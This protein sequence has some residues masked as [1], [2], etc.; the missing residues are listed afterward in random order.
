MGFIERRFQL[1]CRTLAPSSSFKRRFPSCCSSGEK[2]C[3]RLARMFSCEQLPAALWK[4]SVNN[5][6][7]QCRTTHFRIFASSRVGMLYAQLLQGW[8][9]WQFVQWPARKTFRWWTFAFPPNYCGLKTTGHPTKCGNFRDNYFQERKTMSVD[10][11][12][13][14]AIAFRL[15]KLSARKIISN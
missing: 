12:E 5:A 6:D 4:R 8:P 11:M 10:H 1:L 13:E 7:M 3:V 9:F 2:Y 14:H 15:V